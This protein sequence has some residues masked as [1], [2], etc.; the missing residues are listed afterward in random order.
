MEQLAV[1]HGQERRLRRIRPSRGWVVA[2]L[3]L[4]L[5]TPLSAG[6]ICGKVRDAISGD[7]IPRAGVFVRE[8]TG[9]YTGYHGA[10]DVDGNYCVGD[11]PVGVYDLEFRVDNYIVD[12]VRGVVVDDETTGI[13][14]NLSRVVSLQ[15]WPNPSA[16]RVFLEFTSQ[17]AGPMQIE[18]YDA[19][20]RRV[21]GWSGS[22]DQ[23]YSMVWDFRDAVGQAVSNGVY[24]V[25][26]SYE[27]GT[28]TT[29][30]LR[31]K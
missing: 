3:V 31:V 8:T 10:T 13:N 7:P 9:A 27:G 15:V 21:R 5:A 23:H 12:Y 24:F 25:R 30:I 19:R 14:A 18:I 11:V 16:E 1:K 20:G 4:V 22:V 26:A 29:K 2:A 28:I 6:T 17:S